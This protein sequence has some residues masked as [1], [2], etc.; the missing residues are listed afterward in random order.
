M[1]QLIKRFLVAV[2]L[3]VV[4]TGSVAVAGVS[5][6]QADGVW[7]ARYASCPGNTW[8]V[9]DLYVT[10]GYVRVGWGKAPADA[11]GKPNQYT[12]LQPTGW[13][14]AHTSMHAAYWIKWNSPG[15]VTSHKTRCVNYS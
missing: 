15:V 12:T 2:A 1:T 13:R 14:S 6:A 8:L 9:I 7:P 10:K 5:P 11:M 3:T 4:T